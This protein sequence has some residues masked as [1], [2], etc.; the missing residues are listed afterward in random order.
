MRFDQIPFADREPA[1]NSTPSHVLASIATTTPDRRNVLRGMMIA[2]ATAAL[3]PFE[4]LATRRQA[5]AGPTSEWTSSNCTDGYPQGYN[6]QSNNWWSSGPAACFGGWRRGSYPCSGG[7]HFEGFRSY[8][9]EGYTSTRIA[10]ACGAGSTKKNAWRWTAS[11][12]VYRCSD[13]STRT[14]WN[15]GESYT[16]LTISMCRI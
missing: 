6:E 7:W 14:V 13:A 1:E 10:T 12:S 8:S 5:E 15:S 3:V 11:G 16:D 4:W 9:D 2:A